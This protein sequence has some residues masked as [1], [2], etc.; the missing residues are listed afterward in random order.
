MSMAALTIN[1]EREQ[2]VDFSKPF[3]NLGISILFKSPK[4]EKPGLF[5][6]LSPLATEIWI[7]LIAA[8]MTVSLGIFV[9]ARLSPY[10]WYNPHPCNTD[11][12]EVENTFDLGNSMW[13]AIGTLMQQGSDIN[14]RACST[15]LVGSIWWFFTLIMISSYTANLAAFLTIERMV[16]P[17]ESV[18]DLEKQ[19]EIKY[20][21][22]YNG[23]TMSFFKVGDN[24]N[25]HLIYTTLN[26]TIMLKTHRT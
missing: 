26:T 24:F 23:T 13:F 16:S 1:Y 11:S 8:Y 19:T 18:E 9:L 4:K 25:S 21:T 15:R 7:Y 6:F 5:S 20:G 14:P 12:E 2:F 3:L 22:R 10:E 17:I